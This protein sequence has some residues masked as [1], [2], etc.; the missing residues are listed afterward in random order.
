MKRYKISETAAWL[1][2]KSWVNH[3]E[4]SPGRRRMRGIT[5][6]EWRELT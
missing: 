6:A 3:P 4:T 1:S 5:T 2:I